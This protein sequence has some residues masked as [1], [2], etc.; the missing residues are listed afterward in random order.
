MQNNKIRQSLRTVDKWPSSKDRVHFT[1]CK[2]NPA[3]VKSENNEKNKKWKKKNEKMKSEIRKNVK[4]D[5]NWVVN[6]T[7]DT[8]IA[9]ILNHYITS[10]T[11]SN[12]KI[13]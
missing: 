3:F 13:K 2:R 5:K 10:Y 12:I 11:K 7:L 1:H 9:I 4:T 8:T 6:F